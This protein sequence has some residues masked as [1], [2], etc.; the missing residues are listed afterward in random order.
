VP[1]RRCLIVNA[2]DFGQSRG[3]NGGV[4]KAHEHGIVTSASLMTRWPATAEAARYA[5]EHPKL[6]VGLHI[7]LGEWVHRAG[8]WEPIYN[9]V[10]RDD[11]EAV[12]AEVAD[13]LGTF[14][15]LVDKE[16]THLD[17]HQN[18]HL[19]ESVRSALTGIARGLGIP[20]RHCTSPAR[21]CGMFYGQTGEGDP[22]LDSISVEALLKILEAL[23]EGV[24]EI[25]CHPADASDLDTMYRSER[26]QELRVLCDPRIR[27]AID[28]MGIELCSFSSL[29]RDCARD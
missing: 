24:T 11:V 14:R 26:K 19:R 3:V 17:S 25:G 10:P 20:L 15:Q 5:V 18:V 16:P 9:V 6:S 7:D 22:L 1:G 13:Q 23:P 27:S 2:D 29:R 8:G 12:S 21:H 28:E 4:M